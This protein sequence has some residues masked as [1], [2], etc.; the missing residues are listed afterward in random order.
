MVQ[1]ITE[2]SLA[3]STT[4]GFGGKTSGVQPPPKWNCQRAKARGEA[5][6]ISVSAGWRKT[7]IPFLGPNA[8]SPRGET[9]VF[10]H[11]GLVFPGAA[12]ERYRQLG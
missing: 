9:L 5:D 11:S 6:C 12:V 7:Y 10:G 1:G 3:A 8:G 2:C 4:L